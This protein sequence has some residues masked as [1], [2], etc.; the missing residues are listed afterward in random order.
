M[1]PDTVILSYGTW[2]NRFGGQRGRDRAE[3]RTQRDA[4]DDCRRAAEELS[5]RSASQCGILGAAACGRL[6]RNA[7]ELPRPGRDRAAE[8][9]RLGRDGAGGY[10]ADRR[11]NWKSSIRIRIAGKA[12][13]CCRSRKSLSARSVRFCWCC[14]AARRLL[15]LIACVNVASLLLVRTES[16]RREIAVRGALGASSGAADQP[17]RDRRSVVLAA[18]GSVLGL[19]RRGW[20]MR[21]LTGLDPERH[22]GRRCRISR[23]WA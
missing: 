3:N 22:A 5:I 16:R 23:D 15:L 10:D 14:W 6:L 1:R 13:A 19:L 20:A 18:A 17:V 8:R 7:T 11:S 12:P 9:R 2:Q 4:H 21:L